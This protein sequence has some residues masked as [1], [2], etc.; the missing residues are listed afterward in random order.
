MPRPR[1]PPALLNEE[2]L[3]HYAVKLL[4]QQMRTV[5]EVKR[6][7][8]RRVEADAAGAATIESVIARLHERRY[9]DD[10]GYAQDYAKLRQ[11]NASLGRR[12]V[13]QDLMR[14]GVEAKV[15]AKTLDA[16]YEGVGEEALARRHLE[17]KRTRKP[18]NEKEAARV[19]RMLMRAGFSMGAIVRILKKWDVDESALTALETADEPENEPDRQRTEEE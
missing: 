18:S 16:A 19:A 7:L 17:R 15:I 9:L 4:G 6:L 14:K 10:T 3:Y 11:E 12:R 13:Q 8:R 2:G 5:A 1:K